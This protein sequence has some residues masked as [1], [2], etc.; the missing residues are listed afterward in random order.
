MATLI[1]SLIIITSVMVYCEDPWPRLTFMSEINWQGWNILFEFWNKPDGL[2]PKPSKA[3]A[4]YKA[5]FCK[6]QA[7]GLDEPG[8]IMREPDF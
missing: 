2:K 3:G 5:F 8:R 7:W 1:N 6:D 4:Y